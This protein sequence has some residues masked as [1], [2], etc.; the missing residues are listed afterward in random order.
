MNASISSASAEIIAI[1]QASRPFNVTIEPPGSKSETNR[2]LMLGA[3]S[4]GISK[5]DSPLHA[6]DTDLFMDALRSI[7]VPI[8]CAES[9]ANI[10]GCN[11]R[12]AGGSTV[13]LGDG[14]TPTRFMMA[15]ATL[16]RKPVV[17]DGSARMRERPIAE[18]V[19]LLRA[20][21]CKIEY[22][23]EEGRLP[24]R[25]GGGRMPR[26]GKIE[27]GR[28]ASSQFISAILMLAP[29]L[30]K[31]VDLFVNSESLTSPSYVELTLHALKKWGIPFDVLRNE[32]G[33]ITRV[34]VPHFDLS[35]CAV[36]IEPDASSAVYFLGAASIVRDARVTI[37]GL[38]RL[39][40]QP[41]AACLPAF[42][43]MGAHEWSGPNGMGIEGTATL[44][45]IDVDASRWPDGALCVAAVGA[46]A[47]G[48]TRI[49]GLETLKV[50]E[51]N[52]VQV[53]AEELTKMGCRVET[54]PSSITID[55]DF[56]TA[57]PILIDPRGDHRI[58]MTFAVLGLSR[59]GISIGD[60]RC[61][62]KSYPNFW[63][64]FAL[65]T[66]SPR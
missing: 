18:G 17:I 55:P 38:P 22:A 62:S 54:T 13:N 21:G 43:S 51:S 41:D 42:V 47:K 58:A 56:T 23:E 32:S 12:F 60:P 10:H 39:S 36:A 40:R 59:P 26:G 5:L 49:R 4:K 3:L 66:D 53:L 2:Y 1:S 19:E 33:Q 15:I 25:V 27:V 48:R 45:G 61:V 30:E 64:D 44:N 52:R 37:Q 8:D 29:R 14:G 16:A 6:A 7:G 24:V 20:L 50:K 11:S 57:R 31:G 65:L 63:R 9:W 46:L 34:T 35:S 28:T